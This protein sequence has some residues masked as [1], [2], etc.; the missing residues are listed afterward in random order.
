MLELKNIQDKKYTLG[1]FFTPQH[2]CSQL[3]TDLNLS[4]A[5][6][7]EPSFGTGHFLMALKH[8]PN[9]K[10]GIELD[11]DLFSETL[12]DDKTKLLN[13]N[14]YDFTI[15]T[16]QRLVFVGNPPFR[17]PA[18]SLTTHKAFISKLTK[19]HRVLGIREEA[20]FFIL[21]TIDLIRTNGGHGELHYIIPLTLLKNNS[22]FYTRFKQYLKDEC[23]FAR[24]TSLKGKEFEGVAQDLVFMS[25]HIRPK[26]KQTHP[27]TDQQMVMADD[28]LVPLDEYLCLGAS[29]AIPF[30]QIFIKTYLG[31]VPCES[32][33]MSTPEECRENFQ[34]RLQSIIADKTITTKTLYER[35]QHNGRFHLKIFEK[36][37]ESIAVQDKLKQ[38]LSYVHNIQEKTGILKE[39]ANLDNF[40]PINV[41]DGIR[42]YFRCKKLKRGKNFV[43]ELNPNPCPSFYFTGNPSH[44][45]TDYFGFCEYDCNRNVSPGANRTVPIAN[46]ED[47]LT[48]SFKDWWSA[49]TTE[50]LTEVF[51]YIMFVAKTSWYRARKK[52]NKRFYFSIPSKFIPKEDR[53]N[54][55]DAPRLLAEAI[56]APKHPAYSQF[57]F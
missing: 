3:L 51:S 48:S 29:D 31:S 53:V 12:A 10:I 36:P 37:Y 32:L 16:S 2:I 4:D 43:Y 18:F 34:R 40:K 45:S 6:I 30:Q 33:L 42:F 44:S 8:L 5:L 41:R 26:T 15:N 39:F 1:Q 47:N 38:I 19:N 24:I 20:V 27:S 22:K 52:A 25:L 28:Q 21:H 49:N 14:F 54:D 7:I 50:P 46:L 17:T 23:H 35:L 13:R 11:P 55:G 9:Q 57:L 56:P